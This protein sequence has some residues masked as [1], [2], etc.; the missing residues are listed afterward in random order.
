MWAAA[1]IAV[2]AFWWG[3]YVAPQ[4]VSIAFPGVL[5]TDRIPA[6]LDAE[7]N[8]TL[9][10][11]LSAALLA[12][13]AALLAA[14]AGRAFRASASRIGTTGW[15]ILAGVTLLVCIAELTEAHIAA[16]EALGYV[17]FGRQALLP[18]WPILLAPLIAAFVALMVLF[19]WR[20]DHPQSVRRWLG[21]GF[22]LWIMVLAHE[23]IQPYALLRFGSSL[24]RVLE[25]TLEIS[26]T[27]CLIVAS[28]ATHKGATPAPRWRNPFVRSALLVAGLSAIAVAYLYH[29]PVFDTRAHS[30]PGTFQIM[31]QDQGSITQELGGPRFPTDRIDVRMATR[32]PNGTS[33]TVAWRIRS[34]DTPIR[35]GHVQVKSQPQHLSMYQLIFAPLI[36][37]ADQDLS[38][39]LVAEVSEG[40]HLH[41]G[42][43]KLNSDDG[44]RL[45]TNGD[46]QPP[47]H[48]I[49]F[50]V[51]STP[52]PTQAKLAA[53][54]HAVSGDWRYPVTMLY[55]AVSLVL[56]A[57]TPL[58]LVRS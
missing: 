57:F 29:A 46:I 21:L 24:P 18:S 19:M 20:V 41:I 6:W 50:V 56:L 49:D 42:A 2:I 1:L 28:V 4:L 45:W 38:L 31:L 16:P 44:L 47:G 23:V 14:N 3:A 13:A 37:T 5:P 55:F 32:D 51:F 11:S 26:G 22:G 39:Q 25:E 15:A 40:A 54:W 53:L 35:E 43:T 48:R 10:N 27:M 30:A 58:V 9:T 33:T 7:E 12:V 17:V 36:Q 8:D 34:D 52:E